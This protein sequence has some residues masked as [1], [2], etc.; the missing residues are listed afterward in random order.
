MA[1][2]LMKGSIPDTAKL[3]AAAGTIVAVSSLFNG[4]GRLAWS[5]LSDAI[6]RKTVFL[7]LFASEIVLYLILPRVASSLL[8]AAIACYLLASYGGGFSTMP[9]FVSDAFGPANVGKIYG[10]MLTAWSAAAI[11]GPFIFARWKGSAL[12]IAAFCLL[13]GFVITVF[14]RRPAGKAA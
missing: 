14:F 11:A 2:E 8:F 10:T 6:G 1:Q 4:L 12:Y 9:A 7:I 5:W 3:A 13:I